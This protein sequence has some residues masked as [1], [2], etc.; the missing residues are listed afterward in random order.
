MISWNSYGT[1]SNRRKTLSTKNEGI[2]EVCNIS[3]HA[4]CRRVQRGPCSFPTAIHDLRDVAEW[5]DLCR[6][7]SAGRNLVLPTPSGH[8]LGGYVNLHDMQVQKAD[9][10]LSAI[11][12]RS[13]ISDDST[14]ADACATLDEL[15]RIGPHGAGA[16]DVL[17]RAVALLGMGAARRAA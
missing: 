6:T 1:A 9:H 17:R 11:A 3:A 5:G 8:W 16:A 7:I 13:W 2:R 12:I 14:R 15:R 10:K 4:L